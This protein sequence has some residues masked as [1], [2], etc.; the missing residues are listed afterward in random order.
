MKIVPVMITCPGRETMLEQTLNSWRTTDCGLAP[1]LVVRDNTTFERPQTRQEHNSL[2]A[3]REAIG[4]ALVQGVPLGEV[5]V[6]FMEDDIIFNAHLRHNLENWYPVRRHL[7]GAVGEHF[8][9]SLYDCTIRELERY[10]Q[11]HYFVADP[12]AVYGSQCFFMSAATAGYFIDHWWEVEGMQDIKMSRLAAQVCSI[13]YHTPSLVQHVGQV[14]AW[15]T[16]YFHQTNDFSADWKAA[17]PG[18]N[19]VGAGV[20]A[21]SK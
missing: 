2:R 20:A 5:F 8:F 10:P 16:T 15:G 6:L 12:K 4:Q 19:L 11:L 21:A 1:V 7:G 17:A 18:V 3:L 14:S 9:A 13:F